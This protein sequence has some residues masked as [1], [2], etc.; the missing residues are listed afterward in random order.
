MRTGEIQVLGVEMGR[1]LFPQFGRNLGPVKL[2]SG[3]VS[4]PDTLPNPEAM[5]P[6]FEP[7]MI[8]GNDHKQDDKSSDGQVATVVPTDFEQCDARDESGN[9]NNQP[10]AGKS[11]ASGG[12]ACEQALNPSDTALELGRAH[13]VWDLT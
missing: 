6:L 7:V 13:D 8:R 1:G 4:G 5:N 9:K 3:K 12:A 10:P 11:G 2:H